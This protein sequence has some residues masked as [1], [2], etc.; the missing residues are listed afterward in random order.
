[1]YLVHVI[2]IGIKMSFVVW[3]ANSAIHFVRSKWVDL[4]DVEFSCTSTLLSSD[5]LVLVKDT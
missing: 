4:V 5:I 3:V 2:V 1:V